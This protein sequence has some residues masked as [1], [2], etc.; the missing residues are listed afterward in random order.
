M[1][2]FFKREYELTYEG[3]HTTFTYLRDFETF[4][5]F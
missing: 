2:Q 4:Y 1:A 5:N 3:R